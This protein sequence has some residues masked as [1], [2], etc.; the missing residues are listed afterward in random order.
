MLPGAAGS[1]TVTGEHIEPMA[2]QGAVTTPFAFSVPP[3]TLP[4]YFPQGDVD[5]DA[6]SYAANYT[7]YLAQ[8]LGTGNGN[9]WNGQFA[10]WRDH[11]QC[12]A[13]VNFPGAFSDTQTGTQGSHYTVDPK[14]NPWS[15]FSSNSVESTIYG[16]DSGKAGTC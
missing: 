6:T 3:A 13:K 4:N 11:A 7:I 12:F 10:E 2:S 5:D 8:N 1:T 15:N 16:W 9:G 14:T